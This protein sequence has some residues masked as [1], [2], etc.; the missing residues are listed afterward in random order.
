MRPAAPGLLALLLVAV[1]LAAAA[2]PPAPSPEAHPGPA[3]GVPSP[4]DVAPAPPLPME[5]VAAMG[6]APVRKGEPHAEPQHGTGEG[7][8]HPAPSP[9]PDGG[10]QE[11]VFD[12]LADLDRLDEWPCI[13]RIYDR[14]AGWDPHARGD[15]DLGG[16][17]GLPQRHAGAWGAPP[18]PW[19]V[20]DQVAWTLEYAD[21]RYGDLCAAW[22]AWKARGELTDDGWRGGW[23]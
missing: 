4:P 22:D 9:T 10:V 2:R 1:T 8:G 23:W 14:E 3:A 19:P 6:P 17:Y 21:G 11:Q 20:A 7:D 13:E 5:R 18:D 12:I 16:S 15:V